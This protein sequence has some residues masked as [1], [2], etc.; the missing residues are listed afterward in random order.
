MVLLWNQTA[1][2]IGLELLTYWKISALEDKS[3]NLFPEE[4]AGMRQK[5]IGMS[6]DFGDRC[7]RLT[8]IGN[9]ADLDYF[10]DALKKCFCTRD[11]IDA[12]KAGAS[13]EDPWTTT[14]ARLSYKS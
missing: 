12:W 4:E 14:V 10:V 11:E 9:E 5:L 6:E 2:S 13:F 8:V 1:G 3:L 7:C